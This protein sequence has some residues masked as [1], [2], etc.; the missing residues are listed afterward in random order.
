M[1]QFQISNVNVYTLTKMAASAFLPSNLKGLFSRFSNDL[2]YYMST[3]TGNLELLK[4]F[5]FILRLCTSSYLNLNQ[6]KQKA[7]VCSRKSFHVVTVTLTIDQV[8]LDSW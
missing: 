1:K 7:K 8:E 3:Q 4:S 5:S 6:Y 2:K